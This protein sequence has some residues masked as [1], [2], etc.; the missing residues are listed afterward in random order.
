MKANVNIYSFGYWGYGGDAH[1]LNQRLQLFNK[2]TR[3]RGL[4]W[5]D[6]RIRRSVR[7]K[8]F[9]GDAPKR[10]FGA[11][12][13]EWIQDFGNQDI[14]DGKPGVNI[15]N[16]ETGFKQLLGVIAKARSKRLDIILFCAC[17]HLNGCH[18]NNVMRWIKKRVAALKIQDVQVAGEFPTTQFGGYYDRPE[19]EAAFNRWRKDHPF[20]LF[21]NCEP[22]W[23]FKLHQSNCHHFGTP[24]R[25]I[26]QDG[27][28]LTR[29]PK[30]CDVNQL[31]LQNWAKSLKAT[32]VKCTSCLKQ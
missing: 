18:R 20:G 17:E 21:L 13:Y 6:L 32:V 3:G 4:F 9:I 7:A 29:V 15:R 19:D 11:S 23:C 30:K 27:W 24:S 28:F 10:I 22:N 14:L 8:D 16:Y 26:G 1:G 2:K 5:V 12:R 25:T 31:K